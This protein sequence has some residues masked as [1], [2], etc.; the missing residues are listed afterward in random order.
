MRKV[1]VEEAGPLNSHTLIRLAPQT[2]VVEICEQP[3]QRP[4][5]DTAI[6]MNLPSQGEEASHRG[7]HA[8]VKDTIGVCFVMYI[9][10]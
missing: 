3:E 10:T 8:R 4:G 5:W 9:N 1:K 2:T 7:I 6:M